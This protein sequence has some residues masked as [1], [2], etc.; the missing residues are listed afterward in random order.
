MEQVRDDRSVDEVSDETALPHAGKLQTGAL[1][2]IGNV[3]LDIGSSAV[4]ATMAVT[5]GAIVVASGYASPLVILVCGLPMLGIAAAYRRLGK[6]RVHCGA[7]YDWGARAIGPGY[8]FMVGWIIWLAYVVGAISIIIPLGPYFMSFVGSPNSR[9]GEALIGFIGMV[10][11]FGVAMIGIRLSARVQWTLLVIEL[12]GVGILVVYALI[13]IATRSHG[14]VGFTP[15]WFSWHEMGGLSGFVSAALISVY[16]YSGWDAGMLLG[17]ETRKPRS[18]PGAGAMISVIAL[19]IVFALLTFSFQA[20]APLKGIESHSDVLEYIAHRLA[21]G[22]LAKWI[23]LG[24]A[25]SALGS[26]LACVVASARMGFAMGSDGVLHRVFGKTSRT[27]KTPVAATVI[28]GILAAAGAWI[29][30]LGSSSVQT[31]F[32]HI[33]SVD[34]MLFALFYAGTG[35]AVAVYYRRLAVRGL[36]PF[37]QMEVFPLASS[38]F[39]LYVVG[40]SMSTFGWTSANMISLYVML[41]VGVCLLIYGYLRRTSDFFRIRREVYDPMESASA[42]FSGVAAPGDGHLQP[43]ERA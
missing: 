2:L 3:G 40:K 5:I 12:V 32:T 30:P 18:W 39:L 19:A 43:S 7:T 25:L 35:I 29:Y 34:G 36:W 38:A 22:W 16:I 41:G 14:A 23:V 28:V 42:V 8:G 37:I 11:V 31:S 20:A 4:T 27:F 33:V 6:W 24:V 21:G 1:S 17:E 9:V 13:A 10:V 15:G 26:T